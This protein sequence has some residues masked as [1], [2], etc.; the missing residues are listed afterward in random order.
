MPRLGD[1]EADTATEEVQ[2]IFA[3]LESTVGRVPNIYAGMANSPAALRAALTGDR[4]IGQGTLTGVEQIV[5]KLTVG[6][7][8]ACEY[9]LAA[10]TAVGASRGLTPEQMIAIRKGQADDPKYQAL[11]QFTRRVLATQGRVADTELDAFRAAGYTDCHVVEVLLIIGTLT[12]AG[13][14]NNLNETEL[15]FPPAPAL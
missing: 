12:M 2:P 14:F 6:R 4:L 5:V 13:F 7:H 1:V 9:C 3:A 11:L 8:Y 10:C 15:D